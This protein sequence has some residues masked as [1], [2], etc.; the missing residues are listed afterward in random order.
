MGC[1]KCTWF[2]ANACSQETPIPSSQE[3]LDSRGESNAY[4]NGKCPRKCKCADKYYDNVGEYITEVV[5][6]YRQ[7]VEET[8]VGVPPPEPLSREVLVNSV[9]RAYWQNWGA[10]M[11]SNPRD[12]DFGQPLPSCMHSLYS[13]IDDILLQCETI[14]KDASQVNLELASTVDDESDA[15]TLEL[16]PA[17][18]DED[19]VF[20]LA[21]ALGSNL[22]RLRQSTLA[23]S[24]RSSTS[25]PPSSKK[26]QKK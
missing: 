22:K 20:S 26:K 18:E 16:F 5:S 24:N 19:A 25:S 4:P 21:P 14:R 6:E 12:L 10:D 11:V 8:L 7:T 2:S 23:F 15:E 1:F 17:A 3:S 9:T 13:N